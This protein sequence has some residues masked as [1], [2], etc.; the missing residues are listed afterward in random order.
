M[1]KLPVMRARSR[2]AVLLLLPGLIFR[3]VAFE[4]RGRSGTT[5]LWDGG[6]VVGSLVAAF[7]QGAAVGR[8]DPRPSIV[9]SHA[10]SPMVRAG[11]M[12]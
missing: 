4:F 10:A 9:A 6:F 8:S 7:V 11:K 5:G 3:G 1:Y 12:T 2:N